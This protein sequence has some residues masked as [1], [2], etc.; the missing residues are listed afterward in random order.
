MGRF[1]NIIVVEEEEGFSVDRYV[2][3]R[4]EVVERSIGKEFLLDNIDRVSKF[5][6]DDDVVCSLMMMD[7]NLR[8]IRFGK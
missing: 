5:E 7:Y 3:L 6:I 4:E 2:E 8:E 1:E